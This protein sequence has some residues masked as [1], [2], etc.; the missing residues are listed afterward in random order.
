MRAGKRASAELCRAGRQQRINRI[1]SRRRQGRDHEYPPE[2]LEAIALSMIIQLDTLR[3]SFSRFT[4]RHGDPS[5]HEYQIAAITWTPNN[6][7]KATENA[8]CQGI[9]P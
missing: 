6:T 2:P 1:G 7:L 8:T 3:P 9:H 4:L 5:F